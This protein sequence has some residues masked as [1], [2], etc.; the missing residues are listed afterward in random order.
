MG[1]SDAQLAAS[2][3]TFTLLLLVTTIGSLQS[4]DKTRKVFTGESWGVISDGVL[5]YTKVSS[6]L[7]SKRQITN[8]RFHCRILIVSG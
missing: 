1:S 5:N 3:L 2:F 7:S 6:T 8:D 4:C